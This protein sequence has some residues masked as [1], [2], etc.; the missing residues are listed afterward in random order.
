MCLHYS[1][2][3]TPNQDFFSSAYPFKFKKGTDW[4]QSREVSLARVPNV[5]TAVK[6]LFPVHSPS[7]PYLVNIANASKINTVKSG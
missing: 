6:G 5:A 2:E 4:V 1:H 3:G 7:S